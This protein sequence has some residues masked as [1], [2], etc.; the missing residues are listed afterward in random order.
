MLSGV[1]VTSELPLTC[2]SCNSGSEQHAT[3]TFLHRHAHTHDIVVVMFAGAR[4]CFLTSSLAAALS[5][6]LTIPMSAIA[7]IFVNQ[8]SDTVATATVCTFSYC[9]TGL[10][11]LRSLHVSL[12]P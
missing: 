11:F 6:T 2:A 10:L 1:C 9:L 7:D 4:G 3:V 8:V 5:V 12:G